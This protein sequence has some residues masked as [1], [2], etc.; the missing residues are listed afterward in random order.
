MKVLFQ[1]K[2]KNLDEL[3]PGYHSIHSCVLGFKCFSQFLLMQ[4]HYH[5][6]ANIPNRHHLDYSMHKSKGLYFFVCNGAKV[7]GEEF[8]R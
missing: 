4:M 6:L 3:L 7:K 5:M 2:F 1:S 8:I